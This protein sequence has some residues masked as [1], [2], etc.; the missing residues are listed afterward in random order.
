MASSSFV[1]RRRKERMG[2][3]MGGITFISEVEGV[4]T[5]CPCFLPMKKKELSAESDRGSVV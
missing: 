3:D 5:Y 1:T 2:T 4:P